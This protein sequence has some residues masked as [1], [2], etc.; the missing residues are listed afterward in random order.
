MAGGCVAAEKKQRLHLLVLCQKHSPQHLQLAASQ[1]QPG[2]RL[3]R[4]HF[5]FQNTRLISLA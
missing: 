1:R 4:S 2:E 5:F 3:F